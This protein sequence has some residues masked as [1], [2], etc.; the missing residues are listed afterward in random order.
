[1]SPRDSEGDGSHEVIGGGVPDGGVPIGGNGD[2]G[3]S[4]DSGDVEG[5]GIAKG[6]TNRRG[7]GVL[8]SLLIPGAGHLAIGRP[9]RAVAWAALP[10]L[11][12]ASSVAT[13]LVGMSFVVI[14]R[15]LAALDV[16]LV[17][18]RRKEI[19]GAGVVLA[20]TAVIFLAQMLLSLVIRVAVVEAFKAS[21]G[22]M[23]P[24]VL[25]GDHF[26]TN[27]LA[28][29]LGEPQRGDIAVVV[30]PENPEQS[31]VKRVVALGGD[32]IAIKKDVISVN[33]RLV[34]RRLVGED[35]RGI[36]RGPEASGPCGRAEEALEGA[37]YEV[38]FTS[39]GLMPDMPDED[40]GC[41]RGMPLARDK[42][43]CVVPEGHA[44]VLGDNR[45][46]S[47]D[48]RLWGAVPRENLKGKPFLVWM[49][50]DARGGVRWERIGAALR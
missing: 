4:G 36:D 17:P 11:G 14:A 13:G 21:S 42:S 33:G 25:V 16:L 9:G 48:S 43:G 5:E 30:S 8:L 18:V 32:S 44:F 2:S 28:Y 41:P 27:K 19:P 15:A 50:F 24:T 34:S 1:M 23:I 47:A 39:P 45:H 26:L 7:V 20:G 31:F 10:V 3:D 37:R 49:S 38:I 35:C 12:V 40:M 22:S 6:S 46:N 29:A